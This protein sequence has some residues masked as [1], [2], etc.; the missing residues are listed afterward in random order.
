MDAY[1][2]NARYRR[3]AA[4]L[5]L[6]AVALG[7]TLASCATLPPPRS[8]A[9]ALYRKRCGNCHELHA[10]NEYASSDWKRIMTQMSTNA[11]LS[12]AQS[13]ELLDF[14]TANARTP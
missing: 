14:L 8:P 5:V 2:P 7:A 11:G 3:Q 4:A 9:E 13:S 12:S 6:I 1:H 10:P